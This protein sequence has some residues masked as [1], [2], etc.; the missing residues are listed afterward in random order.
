MSTACI[1]DDVVYI[2]ELAGYLHCL[3]AK[4]GKKYWQYDLKS[5]IWGSAYYVDGKVFVGNEDGDLFVFKHEKTPAVMDEVEEAS[6]QA[7]EKA[8][9]K[10]LQE[11]KKA[12]E[13]KYRIA[14]IE[15]EE[16]IRSTPIVAN[17]VLYIMT[18]RSLI[19]IQ[20]K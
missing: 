13:A 4:T 20:K 6:K 7:D 2:G 12:V 16:P 19:A 10:K 18:E 9:N 11:V 1:V 3:D 8:A 15:V 5:A 17:G 14:K